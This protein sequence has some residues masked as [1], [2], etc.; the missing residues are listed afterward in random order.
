MPFFAD[1]LK[2]IV[3]KSLARLAFPVA[4]VVVGF[5]HATHL[6]SI[7]TTHRSGRGYQFYE[8]PW[9]LEPSGVFAPD[10]GVGTHVIVAF[11]GCD[12]SYP[13]I[14]SAYDPLYYSNTRQRNRRSLQTYTPRMDR[15]ISS[16]MQ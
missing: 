9:V 6:A 14:Q 1:K 7:R 10:P 5:D 4:G 2:D 16:E 8:L 11:R 15:V 13:Y 12:S 3:D